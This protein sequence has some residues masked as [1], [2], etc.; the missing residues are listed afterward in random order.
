MPYGVGTRSSLEGVSKLIGDGNA[1]KLG[2]FGFADKVNG[3]V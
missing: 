3:D 2:I 1:Q